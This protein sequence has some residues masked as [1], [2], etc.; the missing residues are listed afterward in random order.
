[1]PQPRSVVLNYDPDHPHLG[2][3]NPKLG[4]LPN[5]TIHFK[6]AGSTRAAVPGCKL[7]ITL[8]DATHFSQRVL[9]HGANQ[10]GAEDLVVG[11]NAS[12]AAALPAI[13]AHANPVITG[14]LCEL[15]DAHGTPIPGARADGSTGGDIVPDT[16]S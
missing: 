10:T 2:P 13:S 3:D 12:L 11:V 8:H 7:R 1:M 16:G 9:V 14:Y 4:V 15:L 5:D 6:I